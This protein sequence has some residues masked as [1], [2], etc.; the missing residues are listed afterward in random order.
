MIF[1]ATGLPRDVGATDMMDSARIAGMLAIINHLKTPPL[2]RYIISDNLG[3]RHPYEYPS[4]NPLNFTRDQLLCLVAGLY[5]QSDTS[6]C[7]KLYEAAK[8]RGW[9][10]QNTESDVPG[11]VKKFP[12]GPDWLSPSHRMV[13]SICA[14]NRGNLLGY[15]WLF[16]DIIFNTLFTPNR[17]PNQLLAMLS[18]VSPK[19]LRLYKFVTPKWKEAVRSYWG[20]WRREPELANLI[21]NHF[22]K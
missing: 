4:N 5:K 8:F 22:E 12:D 13:L 17:E 1:D 19:W 21:I 20:G 18:I 2:S 14:G 6:S 10:A 15:I 3:V 11:S 16:F 9:R 7:K